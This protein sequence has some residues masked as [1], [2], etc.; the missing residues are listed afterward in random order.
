[1]SPKEANNRRLRKKIVDYV[2]PH[3]TK[4]TEGIKKVNIYDERGNHLDI[5]DAISDRDYFD[6]HTWKTILD[7]KINRY[8]VKLKDNEAPDKKGKNK[9]AS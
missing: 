4:L 5:F 2:K 1:M 9:V 7:T 8:G 3:L 6:A